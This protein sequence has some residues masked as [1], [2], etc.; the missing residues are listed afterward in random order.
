MVVIPFLPRL[1]APRCALPSQSNN[2]NAYLEAKVFKRKGLVPLLVRGC[3]MCGR[4]CGLCV[5]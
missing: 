2:V 5:P 1:L 4:V 3:R